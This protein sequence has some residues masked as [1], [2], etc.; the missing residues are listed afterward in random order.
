MKTVRRQLGFLFFGVIVWLPLAVVAFILNIVFQGVD[1]LGRTILQLAVP[2]KY[3]FTGFGFLL[4][5]MVSYA[6][7]VALKKT[8]VGVVLSKI[9][10][11]G[12]FFSTRKGGVMTLSRLGR[13]KP[14]LFLYSP[15]CPSY[16]WVL[17]EEPVRSQGSDPL[18]ALVNVYYPNVPTIVTGSIFP[19][20]KESVMLLGNTSGEVLDLLLYSLRCP[21]SIKVLPWVGESP[22]GF[23]ERVRRFGLPADSIASCPQPGQ[24][25]RP[26]PVS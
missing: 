12:M 6:T 18:Y 5:L 4:A 9:P 15:S 19:L 11:A 2:E 23:S 20:R 8:S 24:V 14:C 13:L 17:S 21:E 26:L 1:S 22:S 3:V 7:G 16:G 10:V 25:G